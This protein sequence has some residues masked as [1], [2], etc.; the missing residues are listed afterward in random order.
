MLRSME[1]AVSG[2]QMHQ[3]W[4]DV[5]GNNIANVSTPGFKASGVTFEQL[6]AQTL[7]AGAQPQANLGGTNPQQVGLGVGMGAITQSQAQGALQQTGNPTDLALQGDGYFLLDMNGQGTGYTRVGDFSADASGNLVEGATGFKVKGWM[8]NASGVLPTQSAATLQD[9]VIPQNSTLPPQATKNVTVTGNLDST[10]ATTSP[11]VMPF[12]VYDGLGNSYQLTATFTPSGTANQ[13]NYTLTGPTG[14]TLGGTTSGTLTFNSTTGAL[15]SPT[16]PIA[17][18]FQPS[19]AA[20]AYSANLDASALTQYGSASSVTPTSDGYGAGSLQSLSVDQ[21]G[22]ITGSFSNGIKQ[23][24]GQV[25]VATFA[26]PNGLIQQGQNVYTV[27][28][29]SG[30]A[31]VAVAGASGAGTI[32]SG[33]LEGSNVDLAQE[34][35]NMIA[36]ERGFQANA[37]VVTTADQM[38]QTLV[39]LGQ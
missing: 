19:G 22:V 9:I 26:N 13:W 11:V 15:A 20:S 35:T 37:R 36:A 3:Q 6:F 1:D 16:S 25:A 18:T 14:V 29:N 38:L 34:F 2:L 8:A 24:L 27:G 33:T 21:S 32:A 12:Q 31:N 17:F 39:Q 7:N 10:T 23:T 5:I 4:M 28:N 30:P